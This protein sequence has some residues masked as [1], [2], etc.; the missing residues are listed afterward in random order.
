VLLQKCV[1]SPRTFETDTKHYTI[2][3]VVRRE[4]FQKKLKTVL[5]GI[6]GNVDD[7]DRADYR[8]KLTTS[9]DGITHVTRDANFQE[10]KF[11]DGTIYQCEYDMFFSN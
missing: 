5:E 7:G 3:V 9:D 10:V 6:I 4:N 1:G 11:Q 2:N 8:F